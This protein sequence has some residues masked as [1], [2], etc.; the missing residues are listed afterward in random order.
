MGLECGL[1]EVVI[2]RGTSGG[3]GFRLGSSRTI[4]HIIAHVVDDGPA[5]GLLIAGDMVLAVNDHLLCRYES[6]HLRILPSPPSPLNLAGWYLAMCST[7]S[8]LGPRTLSSSF[9]FL[10]RV[11]Q[12]A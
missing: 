6:P 8:C 3:Y 12:G 7:L 10:Y 9:M 2:R 5:T 1:F 11:V 4:G